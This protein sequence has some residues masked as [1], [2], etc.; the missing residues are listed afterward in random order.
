[1]S[2]STK[3]T[4]TSR[5]TQGAIEL[6][7]LQLSSVMIFGFLAMTLGNLIE[8]YYIGQI[9]TSALAAIAFMFPLTMAL[10]AFTRGIGIGA[11]TLIAQAM[12]QSDQQRTSEIV[13]HC[14]VLVTVLTVLIAILLRMASE[15]VLASLGASGDVL[16]LSTQFSRIFLLGF[17]AMGL[18]MVSNGLIR[19]YGNPTFPGYIMTIAPVI[20][21]LLGPVLIFGGFGI[22]PMG[23]NGAGWA[24]VIG[25]VA[26]LA[27]AAYWYFFKARLVYYSLQ[28]FS[29]NCRQIL[30]VGIP[31]AATNLIQ[32]VS[33]G[34]VTYLLAG[35][36]DEV[37]AGFGIASRIE[38]VV[39]MVVIG[40]STSVVP[41]VGQNWSAGLVDRVNHSLRICY[42]GCISW[43]ATAAV[44]MWFGADFFVSGIN[45]DPAVMTV[46]VAFLHIVPLSIGFMGMM[47]V[48]THGFNALRRPLPALWL[49]L[50]RLVLV[51]L[52]LALIGRALFGY[53]G[54]FWATAIANLVLGLISAAWLKRVITASTNKMRSAPV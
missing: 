9:G 51:Y 12:G 7:V 26:Q 35:F 20:Q 24:F 31:A 36:G 3:T 48:A 15:Q 41:L 29:S 19:A 13:T 39:G 52:P 34:L 30:H 32:P 37:I 28:R 50:A 17:P 14:Y 4:Q 49:S 2:H 11:S 8:L 43:G 18:A 38:S 40:I 10:N 25:S 23:L 33:L 45:E 42:I 21:V 16:A 5:Y 44:I 53:I 54:I 47:T 27:L 46:A 1:M 22:T 6:H